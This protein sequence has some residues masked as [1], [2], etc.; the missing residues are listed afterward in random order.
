MIAILCATRGM[1]FTQVD[2]AIDKIR[3]RFDVKIFRTHDKKIPDAQNWLVEQA[4]KTGAEYFL[5][6][7]E[8]VILPVERVVEMVNRNVDITFIDYAVNGWSCSA[9]DDEEIFWCG[10]G[11]TLIKRGVFEKIE[12]PWFRTDKEL[13]LN[14]WKWID[15]NYKYGGLDIWFFTKARESGFKITQIPGECRHLKLDSLGRPETNAGL[16]IISDK[17]KI[18]NYQKI[19]RR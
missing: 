7:E 14:D 9:R 5:F 4:L 15:S 17:E 11:A 18:K 10:L 16:H 19:E 8:D 2:E 3:D 6:I 13:R 12:K 1:I